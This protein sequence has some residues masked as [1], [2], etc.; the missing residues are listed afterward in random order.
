M[1]QSI[2]SLTTPQGQFFKGEFPPG[3]KFK[4]FKT[5]T[6]WAYKK[7]LKQHPRGHFPQLF[8]IET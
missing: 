8:A 6:P 4:E 5:P 7:E 1:Y 2:P 3:K